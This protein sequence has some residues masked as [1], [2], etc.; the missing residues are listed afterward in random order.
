M[1]H[2]IIL[3]GTDISTR[4]VS[5]ID[6]SHG[7]R[8][9]KT[10]SFTFAPAAAPL[11]PTDLIRK[12][13]L[14]SYLAETVFTGV[15]VTATWDLK[16]RTYAISC[17][18]VLQEHF[19][20]LDRAQI[21]SEIPGGAYSTALFGDREDGWRMAQD[22][23]ST[24]T[25]DVFLNASNTL[26]VVPWAA[27]ATP[28]KTYT[29]AN[30]LNDGA[31]SLELMSG[32]EVLTKAKLQFKLR[33]SRWNLREH[34]FGWNFYDNATGA[35]AASDFCDWLRNHAYG[36]PN[37][38]MIVS[39]A[40]GTGWDIK[41]SNGVLGSGGDGTGIGTKGMPRSGWV[42]NTGSGAIGW[43]NTDEAGVLYCT[44][45]SWTGV[46]HW[47]QTVTETYDIEV[48]CPA[49][50]ATYGTLLYEDSVA[51][52]DESDDGSFENG[53]GSEAY[54]WPTNSI[55]DFSQDNYVEAD[56]VGDLTALLGTAKTK[57][58]ESLRKNY[59]TIE[60]PIDPA[61]SLRQTALIQ[62]PDIEAQGKIVRINHRVAVTSHT[63]QVT[64]AV[65]RG[66]GGT[67]PG[68]AIPGRPDSQPAYPAPA[69]SSGFGTFVGGCSDAA[70]Y[71]SDAMM[72]FTTNEGQTVT[73]LQV[74]PAN[75]D[76]PPIEITL[77]RPTCSSPLTPPSAAQMY[78]VQIRFKGPDIEDE[79][80]DER[81]ATQADV[82]SIAVPEDTL[83]LY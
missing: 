70:D 42:C 77:I 64:I 47:A 56:R 16:T 34:S 39:A 51:R 18:D 37:K 10:A 21:L 12:P 9:A 78:P 40:T 41:H 38:E 3:D 36:A 69:S 27:K 54:A 49:A 1:S 11:L 65:C 73:Q 57:I 60:V 17:S 4:I 74:D 45:A 50:I 14:V 6:V 75:P 19:E 52:K 76:G 43:I 62:T 79:A 15:V 25:S 8:V 55:G 81:E 58:W 29:A 20:N 80:R 82:F 63:S 5:G 72:G 7:E 46:K 32:R 59:V 61:L 23:M 68:I 48:E 13:V 71:D 22:V 28:D 30:I 35:S 33:L 24:V 44:S 26:E 31:Y 66:G 83:I 53:D 2:T 67:A